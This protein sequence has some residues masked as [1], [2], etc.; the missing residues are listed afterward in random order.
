MKEGKILRSAIIKILRKNEE[1]KY[2]SYTEGSLR[3]LYYPE[4]GLVKCGNL[5]S[6]CKAIEF[7]SR[8]GFEID[9]GKSSIKKNNLIVVMPTHLNTEEAVT[10]LDT[11][12]ESLYALELSD[13]EEKRSKLIL[14]NIDNSTGNVIE[15]TKLRRHIENVIANKKGREAIAS[16]ADH[17]NLED[18]RPEHPLINV[19]TK[20]RT[21]IVKEVKKLIWQ[22][23]ELGKLRKLTEE[24]YLAKMDKYS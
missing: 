12:K 21:A 5:F 13:K 22:L 18:I 8:R 16:W 23:F 19:S 17:F 1:C 9:W 2:Y 10:I 14:G 11:T 3:Y 15:E 7:F 20:P 24:E 6:T 4:K